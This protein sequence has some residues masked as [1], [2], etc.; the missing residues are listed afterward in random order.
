MNQTS[1][2]FQGLVA[3]ASVVIIV[4]GLSAAGDILLPILF[5][6]F[7]AILGVPLVRVAGELKV[8]RW[9]AIPAVVVVFTALLVGVTALVAASLRSFTSNIGQYQSSMQELVEQAIALLESYGV[10]GDIKLATSAIQPDVIMGIIGQTLNAVI[11]VSSRVLIVV[12]TM[13]FIL[14]EATELEQKFEAAFG[15]AKR[16]LGPFTDATRQVQRYLV[17]KSLASFF[18]GVFI[19]IGCTFI[20]VD[21]PVL[22]GLIAFLFNFVPSIGSIVAAVPPILLALVQLSWEWSI[23]VAVLYLA[24]N[25]TIGNFLEPRFMGRSLGLSPLVVFLSLL[26]WGW[27]WGPVGMLMC[28]PMTVIA[29]LFLESHQDT[30]WIAV[31]LGSPQ[32]ILEHRTA[33]AAPPREHAP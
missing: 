29:K 4:A 15:T 9:V 31:F 7:L 3:L 25:V 17:I 19:T 12:I 20:G 23:V 14:F 33:V 24:V 21:F 1:A 28:V 2:V 22:W 10:E 11:A 5:S 26:F 8:P 32:E 30:R 27:L 16:R 18:T 13:T 6:A